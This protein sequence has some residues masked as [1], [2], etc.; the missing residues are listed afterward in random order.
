VAVGVVVGLLFR[1]KETVRQAFEGPPV[2]QLIAWAGVIRGSRFV[3]LPANA[4]SVSPISI[5][6][7]IF[8]VFILGNSLFG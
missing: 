5:S 1:S 3:S 6:N 2:G 4:V 7:N 8:L